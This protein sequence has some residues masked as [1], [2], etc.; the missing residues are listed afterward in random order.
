VNSDAVLAL[1]TALA[2]AAR[3]PALRA[4]VVSILRS[5]ELWAATWP[6]DP[7]FLRTLTN[8]DGVTALPLFSDENELHDAALRYAWLAPEGTTPRR[9]MPLWEAIQLA[10]RQKAQ[11]VVIDIAS[12]HALELDEGD[13]E[14]LSVMPSNKPPTVTN[15]MKVRSTPPP[16]SDNVVRRAS[17]RP[18]EDVAQGKGSGTYSPFRPRSVTPTPGSQ[19]VSATFGATPTA[20]MQAL[21]VP[22]TEDLL[23]A[24]S[25]VLREFPEVEWACLVTSDRTDSKQA[26]SVALRIEPAF[27][28]NMAELTRRLREV[29]AA[30]GAR[31]DV[32]VLDTPEQMKQARH[33]GT[34][35]YPWR[36]K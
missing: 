31:H 3:D 27:R 1:Q 9:Q 29:S 17:S 33:L 25:D 35:F 2:S 26:P 30:L 21:E 20:T 15:S 18:T 4:R 19:A 5:A 11:L 24:L 23:E 10:K 28:K 6:T 16:P 34:P 12:D 14:L 32:L 8:S 7:S 22:P 13:V 36:K